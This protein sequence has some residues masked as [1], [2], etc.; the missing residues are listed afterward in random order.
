[1]RRERWTLVAA[2]FAAMSLV[3][4]ILHF[5][6]RSAAADQIGFAVDNT[7]SLFSVDLTTATATPIGFTGQFLRSEQQGRRLSADVLFVSLVPS[8]PSS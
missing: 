7:Q 5:S 2:G 6:V 4:G 8:V 3:A 1:M